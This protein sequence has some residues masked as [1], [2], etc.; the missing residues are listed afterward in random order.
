MSVGNDIIKKG[1]AI[2]STTVVLTATVLNATYPDVKDGFRVYAKDIIAGAVLYQKS[3]S[4][5]FSQ[6]I[7]LVV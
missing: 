7:T 2:N 5:W 6:L 4:S 3:G 1:T